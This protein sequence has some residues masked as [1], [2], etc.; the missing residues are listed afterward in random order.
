MDGWY[1]YHFQLIPQLR[2]GYLIAMGAGVVEIA[3]GAGGRMRSLRLFVVSGRSAL[4]AESG[5]G[6]AEILAG[7]GQRSAGWGGSLAYL[8]IGG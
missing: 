6:G 4:A 7:F 5:I 3:A 2:V 8:G 1:I